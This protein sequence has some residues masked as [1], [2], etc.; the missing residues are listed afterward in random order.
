MNSNINKK[1]NLSVQL[2]L[3]LIMILFISLLTV[4]CTSKDKEAVLDC[5]FTE[6]NWNASV[7]DIV[8][9]E[10]TEYEC[11]DSMYQ[12]TTYIFPKDYSDK[13]GSIKYM[14][15]DKGALKNVAWLYVGND[16]EDV[17][18]VYNSLIKELTDKYGKPTDNTDNVNNY[19]EVWKLDSGNIVITAVITTEAKMVQVGYMHPTV[20]DGNPMNPKTAK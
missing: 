6:L 20:S 2:I 14:T 15:D 16:K 10:K 11:Y 18:S 17:M 4:G 8:N 3:S 19:G 13:E 12:G 5:P 9:Y 7:D 1:T